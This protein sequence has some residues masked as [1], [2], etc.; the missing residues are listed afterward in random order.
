VKKGLGVDRG[1]GELGPSIAGRK[2]APAVVFV[3]DETDLR[4][5]LGF[6]ARLHG[7]LAAI[8]FASAAGVGAAGAVLAGLL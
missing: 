1:D 6:D 2:T 5:R 4:R 7:L 8:L 3:G